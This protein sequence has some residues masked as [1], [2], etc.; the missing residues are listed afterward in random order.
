MTR[1]LIVEDDAELG[2]LLVRA[3][4][5]AGYD[6]D[7][8]RDGQAGLHRALTRSY[9][10]LIID[11]GLPAIEGLDLLARL[12]RSG[13]EAPALIL[14]A[15]GTV[16]DRVAGLDGG[17]EDYLVKPFE[18]DEL[19]ARV[20]VLLRRP[21]APAGHVLPIGD[22]EF[23]LIARTVTTD[24]GLPVTL[25]G[26]ES[27]LL[28]LLA[29]NPARVFTRREIVTTVFPESSTETLADTYVHYLRRKLG[30][31]VIATVRGAGYQLGRR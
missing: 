29:E 24:D 28:R 13:V 20:R 9:H 3:F 6:A 22:A 27:D 5:G 25:S 11:R 30:P 19:L 7:L 2:E 18:L 14:T 1:I 31:D 16:A 23:D 21:A 4:A 17:A 26:R 10:A 12:R 15:L 8:A